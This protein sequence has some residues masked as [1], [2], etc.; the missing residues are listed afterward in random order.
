[1]SIKFVFKAD[2]SD[3]VAKLGEIKNQMSSMSWA[4]MAMGMH[5]MVG[6][7]N[8]AKSAISSLMAPA[9][10]L[11]DMSIKLGVMLNDRAAGD[12]LATSFER[13]ATNGVVS[14]QDL[15]GAAASLVGVFSDPRQVEQWVPVLANIAAG[16]RLSAT[17]IAEM[18]AGLNDTGKAR[19]TEMAKAGI[20]VY[21]TL[22]KTMGLTVDEVKKLQESGDLT[23]QH[24]LQAFAAMT[25]EG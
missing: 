24:L 18:V 6:L 17:Q 8:Q 9:A 23:A 14:L 13:L 5:A 3:V 12:A 21:Q 7:L 2:N 11:E 19:L 16:S 10:A 1:M 25:A 20:P 22:A 15:Q 4:D